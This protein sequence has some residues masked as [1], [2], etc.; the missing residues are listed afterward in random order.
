VPQ[1]IDKGLFYRVQ[2]VLKTKKNPQGRHRT[3]GD[4]LLTGKL[5]CGKCKTPMVGISGTSKTGNLH[6][7]YICQKRRTDKSCDKKN[8]RRDQIELTVATA[9]R[10]YVIQD[11][12]AEQLADS[13]ISFARNY[14][15]QSGIG[16]LEIQLAENKKA[17]KN[18]L[19]AI[20]QG[21]VT[22]STKERL[23]E[24]EREQSMLLSRL[25]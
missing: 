11:E 8:V 18:L 25:A 20:E 4:Y 19:S 24:L 9:I 23:Q 15:E 12:V 7:Y 10:D 6:H 17:T 3:N 13:A 2:E 22:V 16:L 14:K 21:I 1:I 5:F